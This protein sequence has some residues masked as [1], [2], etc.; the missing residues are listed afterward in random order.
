MTD[1]SEKK[2]NRLSQFV[3]YLGV[4]APAGYLIGLSYYQGRLS[5]FGISAEAFPLAIQDAYVNAYYAIGY[6]LLSVNSAVSEFIKL[7]FSWPVII[8]T[9]L[10]I[11]SLIGL[12]Y[13]L[14]KKKK[15]EPS[16]IGITNTLKL[17][18]K[19]S[20][21]HWENND[22][23]K[24]VVVAG[25]ASYGVLSILSILVSLAIFWLAIPALSYHIGSDNAVKIRSDYLKN[26]CHIDEQEFWGN[27]HI[28]KDKDGKTVFKGI[29]VVHS[30]D[31][32]AF[33]NK[34]GSL[35]KKTPQGASIIKE[36]RQ[37]KYN[38]SNQLNELDEG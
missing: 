21:L 30:K 10:V 36:I 35:V 17:K 2:V 18:F 1:S 34:T 3:A 13:F 38:K 31:H 26:D 32:V 5:A 25:L 8:Y 4:F 22:F 6:G 9:I 11:G 37:T 33:F 19:T 29:L 20:N 28:L 14:I 12:S 7:I 15:R 16:N 24:A 27:C 23:T